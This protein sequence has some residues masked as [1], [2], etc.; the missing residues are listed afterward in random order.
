M[1]QQQ[2]HDLANRCIANNTEPEEVISL[3][4]NVVNSTINSAIDLCNNFF[5]TSAGQE[6]LNMR[7]KI[8]KI[9][10]N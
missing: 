9:G 8:D 2:K 3:V 6:Y 4:K 10:G 7:M 1:T 5:E